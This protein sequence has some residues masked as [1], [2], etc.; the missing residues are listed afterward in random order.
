[1]AAR[2]PIHARPVARARAANQRVIQRHS[3]RRSG[4][5]GSSQIVPTVQQCT[6]FAQRCRT[7]QC[8]GSWPIFSSSAASRSRVSATS[9]TTSRM[10]RLVKFRRAAL[11]AL[12]G[13]LPSTPRMHGDSQRLPLP[14]QLRG[15]SRHQPSRADYIASTFASRSSRAATAR[16]SLMK[17]F[18]RAMSAS[19]L[20]T[21]AA[22]PSRAPR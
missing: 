10:R 12:W 15:A 3:H 2:N 20:A 9:S 11:R 21:S 13:R 1:M 18:S 16:R 22:T 17:W 7:S 8:G 5:G 6:D 19:L 14:P 4:G